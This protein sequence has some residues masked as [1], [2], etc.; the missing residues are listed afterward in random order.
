MGL[1]AF[2]HYQGSGLRVETGHS[3]FISL[4]TIDAL[5]DPFDI[6]NPKLRSSDSITSVETLNPKP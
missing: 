6:L 2:I 4:D 5:R 1:W 3:F